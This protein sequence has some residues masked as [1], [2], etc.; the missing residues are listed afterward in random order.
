MFKRFDS[1]L[2]LIASCDAID[3]VTPTIHHYNCAL[4]ALKNSKHL[5]IEKP[6]TNTLEEAKK[7]N[8]IDT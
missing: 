6:I 1:E 5:F 8:S 7:I 2:A 3:I 4:T